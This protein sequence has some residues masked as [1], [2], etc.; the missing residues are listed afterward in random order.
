[1]EDEGLPAFGEDPEEKEAKRDLE[2]GRGEDVEDFTEF[3]VL[4]RS[5]EHPVTE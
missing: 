2:E 4:S 5:V 3:D 1:M